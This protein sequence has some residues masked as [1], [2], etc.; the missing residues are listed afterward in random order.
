MMVQSAAL[1]ASREVEV[2]IAPSVWARVVWRR[3]SA[4]HPRKGRAVPPGH[5]CCRDR[6]TCRAARHSRAGKL[7]L[8]LDRSRS[9]IPARDARSDRN[10]PKGRASTAGRAPRARAARSPPTD[11]IAADKPSSTTCATPF[12]PGSALFSPRGA[13]SRDTTQNLHAR[14]DLDDFGLPDHGA[15][16]LDRLRPRRSWPVRPRIWLGA[17]GGTSTA[18][19]GGPARRAQLARRLVSAPAPYVAEEEQAAAVE[20]LI[21]PSNGPRMAPRR[22]SPREGEDVF[23]VIDRRGYGAFGRLERRHLGDLIRRRC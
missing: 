21:P 11:T 6:R 2:P 16:S 8:L 15:A 4:R 1:P 17:G 18:G 5:V 9:P 12:G 7:V 3:E 19:L 10:A 22:T 20:R 23:D 13:S 14:D